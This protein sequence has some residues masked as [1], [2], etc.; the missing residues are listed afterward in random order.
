[1]NPVGMDQMNYVILDGITRGIQ[2]YLDETEEDVGVECSLVGF[3]NDHDAVAL[4]IGFGKKF[5]QQHA[6]GHVFDHSA[7][8]CTIFKTNAVAYFIAQL[9]VHFL[10][11]EQM[12]KSE[13]FE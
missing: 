11:G 12:F 6:I 8:R 9:L 1:M 4:Q 2:R 13:I 3:I 10:H 5:S 7:L